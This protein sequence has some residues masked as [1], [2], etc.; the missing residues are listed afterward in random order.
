M[1]KNMKGGRK[2]DKRGQKKA[3]L[4]SVLIQEFLE[5]QEKMER[6]AEIRYYRHNV[7]LDALEA[8]NVP[9]EMLET[10]KPGEILDEMMKDN[11]NYGLLDVIENEQLVSAL[12]KIKEFDLSILDMNLEESV[13]MISVTAVQAC[14]WPTAWE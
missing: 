3:E 12:K 5:A 6:N 8:F 1:P 9:I 13:S 14:C 4:I 7:S 10:E 2:N 11:D